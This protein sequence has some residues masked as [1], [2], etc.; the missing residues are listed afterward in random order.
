[1]RIRTKAPGIMTHNERFSELATI[2]ARG[3]L[4]TVNPSKDSEKESRNCL[5]V[6]E[7]TEAHCGLV[8]SQENIFTEDDR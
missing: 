2:L 5:D 8:Y 3:Y 1:M 6:L 7:S 4:R